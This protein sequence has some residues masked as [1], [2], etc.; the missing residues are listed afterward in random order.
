M[1]STISDFAVPVMI[2]SIILAGL[3]RKVNIYTAFGQGVLEG[4]KTVLNIFGPMLSIMIGISMF[5]TS[6]AMDMIITFIKPV[7]KMLKIPDEI[8][9]FAV[10]RPVSGG[11]SLALCTDLFTKYGPDSF[12]G[13]LASVIMGSTETTFYTIAVYFGSVGIKNISYSLKCALVA[14]FVGIM[15]SVAVVSIFFS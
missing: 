1:I 14:D 13:R 8:I 3:I 4:L 7:S 12:V 2:V 15:V 9:P 5:R 10:M 6:G 11:G